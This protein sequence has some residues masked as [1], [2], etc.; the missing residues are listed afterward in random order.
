MLLSVIIVARNEERNIVRCIS[1]VLKATA[2]LKDVEVLLV[3]SNSSDNT[4]EIA[5]QFPINIIRLKNGWQLSPSAGRFSG[6]N[7]TLGEYILIIDGDM[8]LLDGWVDFALNYFMDHNKVAAV[9]GRH[10]DRY[11]QA[12]MSYSSPQLRNDYKYSDKVEKIKYAFGS[13]IF[14]RSALLE[15]GNFHPYLRGEEEAEI[16]YRL[17]KNGYELCILPHDAIF[18]YCNPRNSIN[19]TFRRKKSGLY[20][21]LGDLMALS[22]QKRFYILIWNR[23]RPFIIYIVFAITML[24]MGS[25]FLITHF[26]SGILLTALTPILIIIILSAKK[27]SMKNGILSAINMGFISFEIIKG[28]FRKIKDASEYPKDVI[29]VKQ[30]K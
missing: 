4:I 24:T 14:R 25:Y 9:M 16:S 8:E 26:Y 3:D 12:N 19:E 30:W 20:A 23:F 17:L 11:I 29:S 7:N 15:V 2:S 6:V 21:G 27:R 28:L 22:L 18:H 5:K 1:S 13:A 10:Y